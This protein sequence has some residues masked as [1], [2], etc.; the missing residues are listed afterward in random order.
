MTDDLQAIAKI[1]RW[2]VETN[3]SPGN[4]HR[5]DKI[6]LLRIELPLPDGSS[7]Y[8]WEPFVELREEKTDDAIATKD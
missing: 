8:E 2:V 5:G 4:F 6:G 7:C 3:N 1:I